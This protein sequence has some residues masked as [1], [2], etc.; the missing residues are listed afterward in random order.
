MLKLHQNLP[1]DKFV[2]HVL[3]AITPPPSKTEE[4]EVQWGYSNRCRAPSNNVN[5]LFKAAFTS[6]Y[7]HLKLYS[8]MEQLQERVL[9]YYTDGL[10]YVKKE[11]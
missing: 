6:V 7:G 11:G 3:A 1:K 9:Y 10:I 8:F 4:G 5:N 2:N